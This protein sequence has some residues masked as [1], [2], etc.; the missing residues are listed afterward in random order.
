ME[1]KNLGLVKAIFRQSTEPVRTDVLWY[2]TI[3]NVL[4]IYDSVAL[5]WLPKNTQLSGGLTDGT[6]TNT[7][8][9]IVVGMTAD[10]AGIGYKCTIRDT[11]STEL[12]YQ[13]ESDGVSWEYIVMTKAL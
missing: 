7:E 6:P 9:D 1:T 5:K 13:I 11:T 2:D 4:K 12:L 3:N 10:V 8:I